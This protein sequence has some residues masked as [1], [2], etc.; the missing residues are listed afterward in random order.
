MKETFC[1]PEQ[2]IITPLFYVFLW[3]KPLKCDIKTH[4]DM[5]FEKLTPQIGKLIWK[6]QSTHYTSSVW[7]FMQS[8]SSFLITLVVTCTLYF[9]DLIIELFYICL[10]MGQTPG[11]GTL[12]KVF[13]DVL[14]GR[15]RVTLAWEARWI[16]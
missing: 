15:R 9:D 7:D 1:N 10:V 14:R 4:Y 3:K 8:L 6:T 11:E 5:F 12:S 13:F 16:A 2:A